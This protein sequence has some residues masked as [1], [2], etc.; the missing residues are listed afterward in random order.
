MIQPS[1]SLFGLGAEFSSAAAL[2]EAAKRIHAHGFRKWDV[3]SPFPIHGMDHAMGFK[4]SRV[5]LFSLLG[6]C[7]GLTVAFVL[8]YYTSAINYPL[9]V[10]GKPY[11]AL[12]PS[13]P[14]FF[15]L[16][17]LLTAFGT[18]LGL[19]LLT[20]LPRLHHP[21]FN[22]DRF[23][24]ATDDGFFL[25]LESTDPRFESA[26]SRQLL[27]QIGGLHITEIFQDPEETPNPVRQETTA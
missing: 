18:V 9:I 15:E 23:Q 12:E 10:Q 1:S 19:L 8:I 22:W 11:F 26:S 5:S 21:V 24:K 4:R 17:I 6:G 27:E 14:I 20:L 7:T 3:Y 16:T 13:L 25:V 2:L